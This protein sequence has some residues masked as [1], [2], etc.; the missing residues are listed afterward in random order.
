MDINIYV[1]HKQIQV[2]FKTI[3][4]TFYVL[5]LHKI[6][7]CTHICYKMSTLRHNVLD[8]IIGSDN[9]YTIRIMYT[10]TVLCIHIPYLTLA[11]T[12]TLA[13]HTAHPAKKIPSFR[14]HKTTVTSF[15]SDTIHFLYIVCLCIQKISLYTKVIHVY[16]NGKSVYIT[17]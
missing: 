13:P 17:T 1:T 10:H 5:I 7:V 4:F 8:C 14:T 15:L 12:L 16:I 6:C 2:Q 11:L 9:V 3:M